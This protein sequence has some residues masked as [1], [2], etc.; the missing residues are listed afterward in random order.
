MEKLTTYDALLLKIN[1]VQG[2][3]EYEKLALQNEFTDFKESLRPKNII[4][5]IFNDIRESSDV[6][7]DVLRGTLG[8]VSGFLTN[9]FL[10]GSLHGPLKTALSAIIPGLFTSFAIK[11]PDTIKEKGLP[12]LSHLL[13]SLKIKTT[14]EKQHQASEN[15]L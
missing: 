13:Q 15:V 9:K 11:S 10:L 7:Q 12:W 5:G 14:S 6:K 4:R 3:R 2:K 8:L 1:E